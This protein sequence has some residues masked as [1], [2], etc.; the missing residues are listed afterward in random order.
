MTLLIACF[1]IAGFGFH[2]SLYPIA[3]VIWLLDAIL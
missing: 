1:L 2:W 3:V